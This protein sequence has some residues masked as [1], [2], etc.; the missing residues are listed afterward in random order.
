MIEH[1][2]HVVGVDADH[3]AHHHARHGGYVVVRA[4]DHYGQAGGNAAIEGRDGYRGGLCLQAITHDAAGADQHQAVD[5]LAG[6]FCGGGA[7]DEHQGLLAGFAQVYGDGG[8]VTRRAGDQRVECCAPG[9][10]WVGDQLDLFERDLRL[11]G[12]G[13]DPRCGWLEVG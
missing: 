7:I 3:V 1:W 12:H 13:V 6:A 2:R 4:V 9:V 11:V 8:T 5:Q 10:H